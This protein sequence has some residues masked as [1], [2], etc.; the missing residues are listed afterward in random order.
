MMIYDVRDPVTNN[1]GIVLIGGFV[2]ELIITMTCLL[3][4]IL[5]DPKHQN[6]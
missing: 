1:D 3:D 2:G 5:A 4:F 6:F